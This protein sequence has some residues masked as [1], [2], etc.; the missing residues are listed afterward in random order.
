MTPWRFI[1]S[2]PGPAFFNMAVDEAVAR[3]VREGKEPPALRLYEWEAP[4]V[5]IGYFQKISS[6]NTAYCAD[7]NIPV[8]RRLTG[9]RAVLHKNE[10]TYSFSSITTQGTFSGS[11]KDSYT[12]INEA[13]CLAVAMLGVS[14]ETRGE[15]NQQSSAYTS[16]N[17][18]CFDSASYGE[19]TLDNKKIIGSAQKRWENGLLQQGSIPL[20]IEEEEIRNIFADNN[21]YTFKNG[22]LGLREAVSELNL[23]KFKEAVK[24][25]FEK[26]FHIEF[27]PAPL[28]QKEILLA[29]ELK[30]QRYQAPE[31][32]FQR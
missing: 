1:D 13:L 28:S 3:F 32:N 22:L 21:R 12:K 4:S 18:F 23:S 20:N 30:A 11:L 27:I 29:L 10:L 15:K 26:T 7:K 31:W 6:I 17:P 8:V 9:G 19:V 24:A 16:R 25:A 2:G 14:P 5:S